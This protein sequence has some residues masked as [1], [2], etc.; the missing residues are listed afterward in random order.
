MDI[1]EDLQLQNDVI[2]AVHNLGEIPRRR[3]F[4]T[5]TSQSFLEE[6]TDFEFLRTFRF[7]KEGVRHLTRL[8]GG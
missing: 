6:M 1:L 4:K 3:R 5:Q 2:D 8:L 7:S